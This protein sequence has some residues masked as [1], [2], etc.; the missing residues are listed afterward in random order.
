MM[1][2]FGTYNEAAL[3]RLDLAMAA[4]ADNGIRLIMVMSNYW[5]FLGNMQDYVDRA[6]GPGK[7]YSLF[8]TDNKVKQYYKDWLNKII[9][10]TNTITGQI[11]KNDPTVL[12]WEL[13]NEPRIG[14]NWEKNRGLEPG[15]IVCNWVKEMSDYIK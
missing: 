13:A 5:P 8:Y 3:R 2:S 10:R 15:L 7:H 1:P 11:Y 9:T 12:A 6:L 14:N 4:A